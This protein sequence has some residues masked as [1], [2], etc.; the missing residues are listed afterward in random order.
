MNKKLVII[1]LL[2]F[3]SGLPLALLSGTL[4]AWFSASG[5]PITTTGMLSLIGFP[6]ICRILWAPVVDRY[7]LSTLGLRRSWMFATQLC[8]FLGFNALVWFNPQ[9][10]PH[11]I[12]L[13]ALILAFFSATQDIVIDAQRIEYLPK[14]LHGLGAALSVLGYRIALLVGG[15]L[16]LVIAGHYGWEICYRSM[17]ILMLIGVVATCW[18]TE[19]KHD[20][21]SSHLSYAS[22]IAPIKEIAQRPRVIS[23]LLLILFY[24]AGEAFTA[25]TSGSMMPFLIQGLGFSLEAVGYINKIMGVGAIVLGGLVAGLLLLYNSLYRSL[26]IFGILQALANIGFIVLASSPKS[27]WLLCLVIASDNFIAGMGTTALVMLIM[28]LVNKQFTATQYSFFIALASL[29]RIFSGPISALIQVHYDWIGVFVFVF[30][31]SLLFIPFLIKIKK[32][33]S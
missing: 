9:I 6:Y 14:S 18:S 7:C 25:T 20:A 16:A 31:I 11:S 27:L 19:P 15:G 26:Y 22:F 10:S 21:N 30:F 23:L 8:L 1:F 24:K 28:R 33:L 12:A 29:P 4:Q 3:S 2:G 5:V 32:D 13:I 17:A